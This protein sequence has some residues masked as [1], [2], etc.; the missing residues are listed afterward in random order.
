[1]AA[2][3]GGPMYCLMSALSTKATSIFS[4][5]L[6][7]VRITTLEC[8]LWWTGKNQAQCALQAQFWSALFDRY[9]GRRNSR[10][11]CRRAYPVYFG[12]CASCQ[13]NLLIQLSYPEHPD[14][15]LAAGLCP[16]D[17]PK[18]LPLESCGILYWICC[19]TYFSSGKILFCATSLTTH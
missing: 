5:M 15:L 2:V 18:A 7:V 19:L 11:V 12:G 13:S 6:E 8:L 4:V 3:E 17:T 9:V 14:L 10:S 1:M 16:A